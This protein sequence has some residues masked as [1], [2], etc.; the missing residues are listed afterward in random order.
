[1]AGVDQ[2]LCKMK[3]LCVD[4]EL[5]ESMMTFFVD[6]SCIEIIG[7][8]RYFCDCKPSACLKKSGHAVPFLGAERQP[9]SYLSLSLPKSTVIFRWRLR[10]CICVQHSV[11]SALIPYSRQVCPLYPIRMNFL[12]ISCRTIRN[13]L[14]VHGNGFGDQVGWL[15]R[16]QKRRW[17]KVQNWSQKKTCHNKLSHLLDPK[18]YPVN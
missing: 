5:C 1:M 2:W 15:C 3:C 17:I 7:E 9:S 11:I 10:R 6:V 8:W 18:H 4:G 16:C 14:I 12:I 13:D